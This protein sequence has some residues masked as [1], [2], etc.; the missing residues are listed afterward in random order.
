ME[1]SLANLIER[2]SKDMNVLRL[3]SGTTF[4]A[5]KATVIRL[6]NALILSKLDYGAQAYNLA[7]DA[8][9]KRVDIIQNQAMRIATMAMKSTPINA[10]EVECGL[11]PLKLRREELILKYWVRSSP[12]GDKL[13]IN[14]LLT[15]H[16]CYLTKRARQIWPYSRLP[17]N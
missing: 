3:V 15:E 8:T 16:G 10:L 2:C 9:L 4:G 12:L 13:P 17:R 6:Y 7:H 5:D 14:D 11:Q 1:R